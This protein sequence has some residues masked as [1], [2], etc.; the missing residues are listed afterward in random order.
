MSIGSGA[1]GI[2]RAH[3]EVGR[4]GVV[5][6]GRALFSIVICWGASR[7]QTRFRRVQ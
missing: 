2:V 4:V 1:L 5:G 6:D 3:E 7:L